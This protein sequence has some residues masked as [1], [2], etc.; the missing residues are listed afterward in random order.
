V[1][2]A[3]VLVTFIAVCGS[4]LADSASWVPVSNAADV[5]VDMEQSTWTRS[6]DQASVWFRERFAEPQTRPGQTV[7]FDDARFRVKIDCSDLT[8]TVLSTIWMANG[9]PIAKADGQMAAGPA[10][11]GTALGDV[12]VKACGPRTAVPG[13]GE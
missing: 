5:S 1:R 2:K 13:D 7:P 8:A 12:A 6:G 3:L 9:Q 11:P 4:A 10:V